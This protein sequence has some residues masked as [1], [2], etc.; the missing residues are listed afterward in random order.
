MQFSTA[1]MKFRPAGMKFSAAGMKFCTAGMKG[2]GVSYRNRRSAPQTMTRLI[3]P[4]E[5]VNA[6]STG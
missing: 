2:C 6:H 1:G 5:N 4:P 3:N